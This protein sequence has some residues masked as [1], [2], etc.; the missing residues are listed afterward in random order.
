MYRADFGIALTATPLN[1]PTNASGTVAGLSHEWTVETAYYSATV[2]IWTD[3]IIDAQEWQEAF[4]SDEAKE[5]RDVMA[6]YVVVF[7][8]PI[9]KK[10]LV[11]LPKI[12]F[13]ALC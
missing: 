1:P 4:Q 2:P 12:K 13:A 11:R 6:A 10:N 9:D 8:K 3:E 5:V 7:R